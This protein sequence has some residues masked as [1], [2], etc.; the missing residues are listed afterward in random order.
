MPRLA[1]GALVGVA[2]AL[3]R[4]APHP[5]AACRG[6]SRDQ[7]PEG[8]SRQSAPVAEDGVEAEVGG[9]D[10]GK[11]PY[12]G[13]REEVLAHAVAARDAV[14]HDLLLLD[15][16][17]DDESRVGRVELAAVDRKTWCRGPAR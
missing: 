8:H 14:E 9:R 4:A 13:A 3:A 7:R 10:V 16:L 17:D 11:Q 12:V 2:L 1:A 15:E 5:L 6:R